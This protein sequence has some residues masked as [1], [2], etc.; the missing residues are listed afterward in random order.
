MC[1]ALHKVITWIRPTYNQTINSLKSERNDYLYRNKVRQ[2]SL[3]LTEHRS[4]IRKNDVISRKM[5]QYDEQSYRIPNNRMASIDNLVSI[6]LNLYV[7]SCFFSLPHFSQSSGVW[8]VRVLCAVIPSPWFQ[9]QESSQA[10]LWRSPIRCHSTCHASHIFFPDFSVQIYHFRNFATAT[11]C[12]AAVPFVPSPP[13]LQ[14]HQGVDHCQKYCTR[15][16]FLHGI[17]WNTWRKLGIYSHCKEYR[18][19][20]W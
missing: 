3:L 4:K 13:P 7:L 20:H 6:I 2:K 1:L 12:P 19:L 11:P 10:G 14:R 17:Y 8:E 9:R 5:R 15:N 16:I 18:A